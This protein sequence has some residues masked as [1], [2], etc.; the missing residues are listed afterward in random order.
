[1]NTISIKKTQQGFTLIEL[2]IVVAIIGILAAVAIPAYQ[3]YT[4]KAKFSE[5]ILATAGVKAAVDVC[6]QTIG[7]ATPLA[8]GACDA[9]VSVLAAVAQAN[10]T[11]KGQYVG[12]VT[13]AADLITGVAGSASFPL[14]ETYKLTGTFGNGAIKWD[15][16]TA[17]GTCAAAGYC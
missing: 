16:K 8:A 3:T 15:S 2:M 5:V 4:Q 10:G 9:D 14:A 17:P 11:G 13:Y 12:S 1:M 7:G 6:A